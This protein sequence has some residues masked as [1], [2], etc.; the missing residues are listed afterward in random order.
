MKLWA[1]EHE[2][3]RRLKLADI[4]AALAPAATESSLYRTR[5][6]NDFLSD[7]HLQIS[8][9]L[10]G[11]TIP[12]THPKLCCELG[13]IIGI[14]GQLLFPILLSNGEGTHDTSI[15]TT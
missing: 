10:L 8:L 4:R 14:C 11:W 6:D 5:L 7:G 9:L 2:E 15:N 3:M 13:L 1:S 12:R